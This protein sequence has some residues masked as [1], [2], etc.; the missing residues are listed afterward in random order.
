[1]EISKMLDTWSEPSELFE[2][3]KRDCK[4]MS[5]VKAVNGAK[6][7]EW[8]ECWMAANFGM[9]YEDNVGLCKVLV[10][11]STDFPDFRISI[12]NGAEQDCESV[13]IME[14]GRKLNDEYKNIEK[15]LN[16]KG[17]CSKTV[18]REEMLENGRKL[19][20]LV[21]DVIANKKEKYSSKIACHTNLCIYVNI[22]ASP[23]DMQAI[24]LACKEY[25][26]TFASVWLIGGGYMGT[27][28]TSEGSKLQS[29]DGF[30]EMP[31]H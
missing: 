19:P 2:A 17:E 29:I 25:E 10:L 15:I 14:P 28:F 23:L 11:S 24:R 8:R 5:I 21:K 6:M 13:M 18:T 12:E 26:S 27:L 7:K 31:R 30:M 1:M 3:V 16:E 22:N 4:D 9:G 20:M